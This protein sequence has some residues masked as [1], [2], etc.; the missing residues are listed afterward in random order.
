MTQ[1]TP[2]PWTVAFDD[3]VTPGVPSIIIETDKEP[4]PFLRSICAVDCTMTDNGDFV[5]TE[6]DR[7]NA[8]LIAAAPETAAELER[9]KA[10]R[11]ELLRVAKLFTNP[12]ERAGAQELFRALGLLRDA[13]AAAEGKS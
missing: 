6:T 3:E 11:D 4:G 8:A 10:Q 12:P 13:I 1:H 7:A 2:G 5:L 9:V